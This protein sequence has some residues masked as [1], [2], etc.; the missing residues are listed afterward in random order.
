MSAPLLGKVLVDSGNIDA[1]QLDRAIE[2]QESLGKRLG[3]ILM[4]MGALSEESLA[5]GLAQQVGFELIDPMTERV[6]PD[7]LA[8]VE[9]EKAL[10]WCAL[11]L[12]HTAPQVVRVAMANPFDLDVRRDLEFMLGAGIEPVVCNSTMLTEAIRM[13]YG[14]ERELQSMLQS[15]KPA[16]QVEVTAVMD[17]DLETIEK[18]LRE[19]GARPYV[20]LFNFLLAN[21]HASRASDI[22]LD[23]MEDAIR[24]RYRIDGVLR[25]A[26]K[27]PKWIEPGL[28]SRIKVVGRM[29]LSAHHKP[30]EGKVR[31]SIAGKEKDLRIVTMPSQFGER[32]VIRILDPEILQVALSDL[33][34]ASSQLKDY[35]RL[36]SQPQ[37]MIL[38]TGPTG[39]GKST[40]LYATLNRL[41]SDQMSIV[42]VEDPVEYT[43]PGITQVQVDER[44]GLT[45]PAAARSLLRQDPNVLVIGEIRDRE[46]AAVAFQ[47]ALTGH[48]VFATLHTT[49]TVSTVTRLRDLDVP[50]YLVGSTLLGVVAQ[51]LVRR[52]CPHCREPGEPA[53]GA[54]DQLEREPVPL[55]DAFVPGGGCRECLYTGYRGRVG[56]FEVLR[57]N[58]AIRSLIVSGADESAVR[59]AAQQAN[60]VPLTDMA[61][62]KVAAGMTSLQEV[63]RHV[64]TPFSGR[65]GRVAAY[66]PSMDPDEDRTVPTTDPAPEV[67]LADTDHDL[68]EPSHLPDSSA[69][70][71]GEAPEHILVVDD[72]DEILDLVRY[73]LEDSGFRVQVARS[74]EEG[75]EVIE[76]QRVNDPIH[77]VVL[78]VMMPGM[79][80]FEVCEQLKQD[81]ATAFLPVLILS[82]RGDQAHVKDGFRAGADDYLPKPF[83]PEELELR[84]QAL[85]RRAYRGTAS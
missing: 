3:E 33:G 9:K 71:D 56:V 27:L 69:P 65:T 84:I 79:S 55:P 77:L 57:V 34:L 42:S 18:R 83:D 41:H 60:L 36:I 45:F 74:G 80:G 6:E 23:A 47:A 59:R 24:V 21:A 85:L 5:V 44:R 72:S 49:D 26:M 31:A 38:I 52:L 61:L 62:D 28:I 16:D 20:D 2:L 29:D 13:H 39:S 30:Q 17:I 48:L 37:G 4:E 67:Q 7:L 58:D 54:W 50:M 51:R 53:P 66:R 15:V 12:Q 22:H 8:K 1:E 75:L 35:Y 25:Q 73:S 32:C 64:R 68:V 43:L 81:I 11:P 19:G 76:R 70:S 40:T 10:A 82:A 63:A 46:T 78:D 14:L